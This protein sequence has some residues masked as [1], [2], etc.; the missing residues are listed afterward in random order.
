MLA[1]KPEDGEAIQTARQEVVVA[2]QQVTW[3]TLSRRPG[4]PLHTKLLQLVAFGLTNGVTP[5]S[6]PAQK[7]YPLSMTNRR[8]SRNHAIAEIK[9]RRLIM[10]W[11]LREGGRHEEGG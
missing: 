9:I 11:L 5:G 7:Q 3:K 8:S 2:L 4:A 10:Y 1:A 6:V